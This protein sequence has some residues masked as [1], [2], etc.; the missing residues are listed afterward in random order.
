MIGVRVGET[1]PLVCDELT[2]GLVAT[3]RLLPS[4]SLQIEAS[5]VVLGSHV[6]QEVNLVHS[7]AA[8]WRSSGLSSCTERSFE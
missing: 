6:S 3:I 1:F 4:S 5:S 8:V 7:C 2:G